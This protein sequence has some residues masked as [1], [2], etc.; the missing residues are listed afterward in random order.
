MDD[1]RSRVV[2]VLA[3][4]AAPLLRASRII[5]NGHRAPDVP[6]RPLMQQRNPLSVS[7]SEWRMSQ[8]QL[9]LIISQRVS[10]M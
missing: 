3:C 2:V 4:S 10:A 1:G 7:V 8:S 5:R 6:Q 9:A